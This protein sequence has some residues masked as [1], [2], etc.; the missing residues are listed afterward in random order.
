MNLS[1]EFRDGVLWAEVT[2]RV[3]LGESTKMCSVTCDA[4]VERGV[5]RIL[6]NVST[7]QGELSD[8]DRYE[9]GQR[10]AEYY[11]TKPLVFKVAIVGNPPLVNGF[12]ALVASNRG[13]TAETFSDTTQAV[14]WLNRFAARE[15][16]RPNRADLLISVDE[17]NRHLQEVQAGYKDA[18]AIIADTDYSPDGSLAL[19]QRSREY[20]Q[21]VKQYSDAVMAL[22][23]YMET[24][25]ADGKDAASTT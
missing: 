10:M 8:M 3:T 24:A 14:K 18:L 9:L 17:A 11:I 4:A 25:R 20:A 15:V 23:A 16:P 2:G 19:R 7:A 21:A 12:V 1:I 6:V 22:L 13:V 5:N